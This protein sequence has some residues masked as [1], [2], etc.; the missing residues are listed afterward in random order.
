MQS[1][2]IKRIVTEITFTDNVIIEKLKSQHTGDNYGV[3]VN[4]DTGTLYAAPIGDSSTGEPG[5]GFTES[6]SPFNQSMVALLAIEDGSLATSVPLAKEPA[7]R[8]DVLVNGISVDVGDGEECYFSSDEGV[9]AKVRGNVNI[10]DKLYWNPTIAKYNLDITDKIDFDYL[11]S[12]S[13]IVPPPLDIVISGGDWGNLVIGNHILTP[14]A[15]IKPPLEEWYYIQNSDNYIKLSVSENTTDL[16]NIAQIKIDGVSETFT[17]IVPLAGI[18]E[19]DKKI[20]DS[21]FKTYTI[22]GVTLDLNRGVNWPD[23]TL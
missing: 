2:D 18:E 5:Q 13:E 16:V 1:T 17:Y 11:V 12:D 20:V 4:K 6:A 23:F 10:G 9:T 22:G 14:V 21:L 7:G 8:I 15:Y 3:F 19:D